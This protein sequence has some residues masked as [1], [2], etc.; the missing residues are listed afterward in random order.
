MAEKE[1]LMRSFLF[2]TFVGMAAFAI[3]PVYGQGPAIHGVTGTIATEATIKEEHKAA[4]KI[5][6]ATEDGVEHVYDSA[7]GLVVHGGKDTLSDL[8]PGTT[9]ITHY[10]PNNTVEEIDRVGA[11]GLSTTEGIATKIDRGKKEI[12]IRYD[13]GKIEKLKLTDRAAD[14]VGKT[15]SEDTR[16]IVYYSQDAGGKVTHYFKST[17]IERPSDARP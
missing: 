11:G 1:A 14:S 4:N 10:A 12:T 3:A 7:K 5:V 13:N 17:K 9:V 16:I 6:V 15:V 2:L 8:K